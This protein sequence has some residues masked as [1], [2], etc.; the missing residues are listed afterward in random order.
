LLVYDDVKKWNRPPDR[1]DAAR[2]WVLAH[3]W[4]G[5][6]P[7]DW[8]GPAPTA[9]QVASAAA[10]DAGLVARFCNVSVAVA[11]DVIGA[12]NVAQGRRED[13]RRYKKEYEADGL[14][15]FYGV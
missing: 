11:I 14:D 15:A 1:A 9:V 7:P 2:L 12:A 6:P 10:V 13:R 4:K 5:A 8:V 3:V